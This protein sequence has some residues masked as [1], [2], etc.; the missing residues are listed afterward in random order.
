MPGHPREERRKARL[1]LGE[2][3]AAPRGGASKR[4]AK[5]VTTLLDNGAHQLVLA[6]EVQVEGALRDMRGL[7][8]LG[9]GRVVVAA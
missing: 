7:G 4:L 3:P 1:L 9:D 5:L 8:D 2:R 6:V